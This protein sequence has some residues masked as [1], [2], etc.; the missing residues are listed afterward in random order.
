MTIPEIFFS[1]ILLLIADVIGAGIWFMIKILRNAS[2]KCKSVDLQLS[3][4]R[5]IGQAFAFWIIGF[6]A[7]LGAIISGVVW[8]VQQITI[9]S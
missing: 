7:S 2:P 5:F 4:F 1:S 8:I 3:L 9:G 6:F